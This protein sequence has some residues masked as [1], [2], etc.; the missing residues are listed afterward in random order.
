[1]LSVFPYL[2]TWSQVSPVLI[3]LTLAAVLLLWS[4]R[5]FRDSGD[6]TKKKV[7]G[8]IG[9][10]AGILLVIG[11]YTQIA[12]LI[13]ILILGSC[14]IKKIQKREFL[15]NGVNYY[16]ILFILA[17]SLL[18]TGPGFWAFDIAL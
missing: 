16:L 10:I 12:T 4:Y 18:L 8:V 5:G 7:L 6:S 3:R 1:M 2:L 14:I 17:V 13:A 11:L 9:G 15:T